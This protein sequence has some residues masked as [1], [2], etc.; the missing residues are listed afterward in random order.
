[1]VKKP[2]PKPWPPGHTADL[3]ALAASAPCT[4]IDARGQA[5]RWDGRSV[6][7]SWGPWRVR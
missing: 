5:D 6:P 1:M 3:E 7:A 2:E 4:L